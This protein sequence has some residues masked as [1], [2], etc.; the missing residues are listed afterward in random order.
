V[1][2]AG[3]FGG[4][5]HETDGSNKVEFELTGQE[6]NIMYGY[7]FNEYALLYSNFSYSRYNFS[8]KI[9]SNIPSLNGLKPTFET[10]TKALYL[11]T[12]LSYS[13]FFAK[14]ESGYQHLVTT[15]TKDKGHFLYGFSV[16]LSW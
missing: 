5:E 9:S 2:I 6:Y 10:T 15:D 16:G 11:G 7:R 3:A 1:A 8:G 14:L 12:E 4:N 13:S